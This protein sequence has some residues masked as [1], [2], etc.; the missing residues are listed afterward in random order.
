[1]EGIPP[2]SPAQYENLCNFSANLYESVPIS[3]QEE[4]VQ[5]IQDTIRQI[6]AEL[7]HLTPL[8]M[9]Q[10]TL[11][12]TTWIQRRG[13]ALSIRQIEE[14][15]RATLDPSFRVSNP[16]A[17]SSQIPP[18]VQ[19]LIPPPQAPPGAQEPVMSPYRIEAD[20]QAM[21]RTQRQQ[22]TTQEEP[23]AQTIDCVSGDF[24]T[25][26]ISESSFQVVLSPLATRVYDRYR[27]M[28]RTSSTGNGETIPAMTP[29][30]AL[31][32]L[33]RQA[34]GDE[35]QAAQELMQCLEATAS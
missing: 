7:T 27:D 29:V 11:Y 10:L 3:A 6:R 21:L 30:Q 8:E 9:E 2:M 1:M 23:P 12:A 35:T 22:A 18:P 31:Q 5:Q 16:V 13:P 15:W 19:Q 14:H 28:I 34:L 17:S 33:H 26:A 32:T 25:D 24:D 4:Q 20:R